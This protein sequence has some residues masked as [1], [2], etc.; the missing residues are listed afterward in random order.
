MWQRIWLIQCSAFS[1]SNKFVFFV[2][3]FYKGPDP[4]KAKI[5]EKPAIAIAKHA[6][7]N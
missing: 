1:V 2:R 7:L 3:P 4:C 6:Y 5:V